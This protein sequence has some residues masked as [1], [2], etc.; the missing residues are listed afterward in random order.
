MKMTNSAK[1]PCESGP[2]SLVATAD[3]E[4]EEFVSPQ[5]KHHKRIGEAGL[6]IKRT[7]DAYDDYIADTEKMSRNVTEPHSEKYELCETNLEL[8]EIGESIKHMFV[9]DAILTLD[10]NITAMTRRAPNHSIGP[11]LRDKAESLKRLKQLVQRLQ[12]LR[13]T[14][15]KNLAEAVVAIRE[16][17]GIIELEAELTR[18]LGVT[19]AL[20]LECEEKEA[21]LNILINGMGATQKRIRDSYERIEKD[22]I[23]EEQ[24][25]YEQ[26][27]RDLRSADSDSLV[28]SEELERAQERLKK[29]LQELKGGR[30]D[31]IRRKKE[32]LI[33]A[34]AA[35]DE[36]YKGLVLAQSH[37]AKTIAWA[38]QR[39]KGGSSPQRRGSVIDASFQKAQMSR[40][41]IQELQDDI[42][43]RQLRIEELQQYLGVD[44]LDRLVEEDAAKTWGRKFDNNKERAQTLVHPSH[45][46]RTFDSPGILETLRMFKSVLEPHRSSMLQ[47]L[48]ASDMTPPYPFLPDFEPLPYHGK[49]DTP[50]DKSILKAMEYM[51]KLKDILDVPDLPK[52]DAYSAEE[53]LDLDQKEGV[54]KEFVSQNISGALLSHAMCGCRKDIQRTYNMYCYRVGASGS[55]APVFLDEVRDHFT[56][57]ANDISASNAE[58]TEF[59]KQLALG[60]KRME[61]LCEKLCEEVVGIADLFGKYGFNDV[62]VPNDIEALACISKI[63]SARRVSRRWRDKVRR[64]RDGFFI[65]I[66]E[67]DRQIVTG[68]VEKYDNYIEAVFEELSGPPETSGVEE[69]KKLASDSLLDGFAGVATANPISEARDDDNDEANEKT[70]T[71]KRL[72]LY[73]NIDKN[74][75]AFQRYSIVATKDS[76]P[77]HRFMSMFGDKGGKSASMQ[78]SRRVAVRGDVN[79]EAKFIELLGKYTHKEAQLN[80]QPAVEMTR[81]RRENLRIQLSAGLQE[82]AEQKPRRGSVA[83]ALEINPEHLA[84][85]LALV[86]YKEPDAVKKDDDDDEKDEESATNHYKAITSLLE[87]SA[88][89]GGQ[90]IESTGDAKKYH[91]KKSKVSRQTVDYSSQHNDVDDKA[92][93]VLINPAVP[94]PTIEKIELKSRLDDF[95][96]EIETDF[97]LDQLKAVEF[98]RTLAARPSVMQSPRARIAKITIGSTTMSQ[99]LEPFEPARAREA[100]APSH[101]QPT[102]KAALAPKLH[103]LNEDV[104]TPPRGKLLGR[105]LRSASTALA[106]LEGRMSHI[107]SKSKLL[108]F[109]DSGSEI[110]RS[111]FSRVLL[112]DVEDAINEAVLHESDESVLDDILLSEYMQ[113]LPQSPPLEGPPEQGLGIMSAPMSREFAARISPPVV[114]ISSNKNKLLQNVEDSTAPEQVA[115]TDTSQLPPSRGAQSSPTDHT[116]FSYLEEPARFTYCDFAPLFPWEQSMKMSR[117][118]VEAVGD[119]ISGPQRAG[120]RPNVTSY[121]PSE[122]LPEIA[123]I[124]IA[125]QYRKIGD[126]GNPDASA[127]AVKKGKKSSAA[128]KQSNGAR[129]TIDI[130]KGLRLKQENEKNR[131]VLCKITNAATGQES[132]VFKKLG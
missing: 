118:E 106:K 49:L 126:V 111:V 122:R 72:T 124:A 15:Q 51:I 43:L 67:E 104:I 79:R 70:P 95:T 90:L 37:I 44:D 62:E 125:E 65:N 7:I 18:K 54:I 85:I 83:A 77:T 35:A 41:K 34:I 75:S 89:R 78:R 20:R 66:H 116:D 80:S 33:D 100:L 29:I 16:N 32:I 36:E 53:A 12:S 123:A 81:N 39:K 13:Q 99:S 101:V 1:D 130:K 58:I 87:S 68:V 108:K 64:I 107:L 93:D 26:L 40:Q 73:D 115:V 28:A 84:K 50:D 103:E 25:L 131:I 98:S 48:D 17:S 14:E 61:Y 88:G 42:T 105:A 74:L 55:D 60:D 19:H 86:G 52:I 6:S 2:A 10:E 30:M 11:L 110:T 47:S 69:Q 57:V 94:T 114:V 119:S 127:G 112:E 21:L 120:G 71:K 3:E 129:N 102:F 56:S 109:D 38:E 96:D 9:D 45:Q 63:N 92:K 5:S 113:Q 24:R 76:E 82:V 27:G 91:R 8:E 23:T 97:S 59:Q 121:L 132:F 4:E 22:K 117:K 128:H 31:E 46:P